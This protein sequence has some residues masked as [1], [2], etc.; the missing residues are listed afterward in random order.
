MFSI[1]LKPILRT[2]KITV[3]SIVQVTVEVEIIRIKIL[4]SDLEYHNSD[5]RNQNDRT[6]NY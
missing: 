2:I 6:I 1:I 4:N 5:I 3:I